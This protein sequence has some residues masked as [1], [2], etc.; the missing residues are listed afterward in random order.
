MKRSQPCLGLVVQGWVQRDSSS[1]SL[2]LKAD[3][4]VGRPHS[5]RAED[6][7]DLRAL[8]VSVTGGGHFC[9]IFMVRFPIKFYFTDRTDQPGF[10]GGGR[11]SYEVF[12]IQWD[13]IRTALSRLGQKFPESPSSQPP[14]LWFMWYYPESLNL[15]FMPFGVPKWKDGLGPPRSNVC[16]EL[17]EMSV[18]FKKKVTS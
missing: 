2:V 8:S 18:C 10:V 15:V 12:Q 4:S 6:S 7:L 1:Q 3:R 14:L 13:K 16:T 9:I 17:N 11:F 5:F